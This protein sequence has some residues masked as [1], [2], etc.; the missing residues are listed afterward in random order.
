MTKLWLFAIW[1]S[2]LFGMSPYCKTFSFLFKKH[3]LKAEFATLCEFGKALAQEGYIFEDSIFSRWQKGNRIPQDRSLLI[4]ILKV[5]I[6]RRS[7]A[8]ISEA[9][10]FLESAGQGYITDKELKLLCSTTDILKV[11]S[12]NL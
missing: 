12:D 7:I 4:I 6:E 8:T 3:R 5:F 2:T 11:F 10:S 9:N 1:L